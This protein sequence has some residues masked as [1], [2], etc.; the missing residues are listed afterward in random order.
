MT[1]PAQP[2]P[3][4]KTLLEF[5]PLAVF[6]V[7]FQMGEDILSSG[8]VRAILGPVVDGPALSGESGPL[9]VATAAFMVVTPIAL[10]VSWWTMR[11]LPR[12]AVVTAIVVAVFGGLTLWLQDETFIKMKPTIVNGLFA[13]ALGIGLL[14][15]Q[16]YI[17]YLLD[18]ALAL[19]REGWMI[20]TR[21]WCGFFVFMAVLNELVWRTQSTEFW[22][23]FKTFANLPITFVFMICQVPLI[24][25]H[26]QEEEGTSS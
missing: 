23:A 6:F 5:G 19:D 16:S 11:Q 1:A 18:G 20:F 21:R 24:R 9:F 12:M 3:L 8:S 7:A 25:R 10:A 4:L 17:Q 26:M 22:V 15:G 13:L 14:R 2:S